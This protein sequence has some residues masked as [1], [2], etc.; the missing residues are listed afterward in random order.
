MEDSREVVKHMVAMLESSAQK[1]LTG[2][3]LGMVVKLKYPDFKPL[4]YGCTNLKHFVE[5]HASDKIQ[6]VGKAGLDIVYGMT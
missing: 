1:R 5:G 6:I 4:E 3:M 2:V